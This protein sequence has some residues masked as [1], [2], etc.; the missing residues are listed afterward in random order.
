MIELMQQTFNDSFIGIYFIVKLIFFCVIFMLCF[1][2]RGNVRKLCNKSF[3]L[4]SKIVIVIVVRFLVVHNKSVSHGW[5]KWL[6][7][8]N[9]I[10]IFYWVSFFLTAFT[11]C[12][13]FN[14][15]F[16]NDLI[17]DVCKSNCVPLNC[18]FDLFF[19]LRGALRKNSACECWFFL[20]R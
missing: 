20:S 16:L 12:F 4:K 18:F 8:F 11:S 6:V 9:K 10:I 15:Q 13:F 7:R 5:N 19:L 3:Y 1:W 17:L 14:K 2:A